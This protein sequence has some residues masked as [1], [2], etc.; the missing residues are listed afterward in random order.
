M[1]GRVVKRADDADPGGVDADRPQP[2]REERQVR[3]QQSELHAVENCGPA[4]E[5][6][7]RAMRSH[8][9]L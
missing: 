4:G 6:A 2:D 7:G 1:N 3:P 9:D 8:G 5:L